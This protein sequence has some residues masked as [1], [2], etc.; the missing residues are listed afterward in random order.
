M[1]MT[2][3]AAI[4]VRPYPRRHRLRFR[5]VGVPLLRRRHRRR[6]RP[7]HARAALRGQPRV[8][9][10]APRG[11]HEPRDVAALVEFES[12]TN[13]KAVY[14]I[15]VSS[16]ETIG[17]FN[18]GFD[19][20]KLHRPTAMRMMPPKRADAVAS[21]GSDRISVAVLA[22]P[23]SSVVEVGTA[24]AAAAVTLSMVSRCAARSA[25]APV[26]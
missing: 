11:A 20:V 26:V 12:K 18:T 24:A 5:R 2:W 8:V 22:T 6:Q 3:R 1:S 4:S 7:Q 25:A 19:T 16:D 15:L 10:R 14:H 23:A 17:A 21:Q 9:T 13:L